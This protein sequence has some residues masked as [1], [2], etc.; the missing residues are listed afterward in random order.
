MAISDLSARLN[1]ATPWQTCA[2]CDFLAHL[3][4]TEAAALR[5]LLGNKGARYSEIADG[6]ATDPDYAHRPTPDRQSLSRHARGQCSA[7]EKLRVA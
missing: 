3:D 1:P 7:R 4:P 6:L 5:A 2:T